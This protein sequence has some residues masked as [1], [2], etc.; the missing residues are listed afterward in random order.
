[1]I[2]W[3]ISCNGIEQDVAHMDLKCSVARYRFRNGKSYGGSRAIGNGFWQIILHQSGIASGTRCSELNFGENIIPRTILNSA[4][5]QSESQ[6]KFIV[7]VLSA[8]DVIQ[9]EYRERVEW[10]GLWNLLVSELSEFIICRNEKIVA[11]DVRAVSYGGRC[12]MTSLA[13]SL[14]F[15]YFLCGSDCRALISMRWRLRFSNCSLVPA[16]SL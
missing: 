5:S 16:N 6:F 9:T 7:Y 13:S 14:H 10:P 8:A 3:T 12:T 1:M 2:L 11:A 15:S 4:K